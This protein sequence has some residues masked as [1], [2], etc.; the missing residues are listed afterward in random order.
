MSIEVIVSPS[1]KVPT[2]EFSSRLSSAMSVA[3]SLNLITVIRIAV[4]PEVEPVINSPIAVVKSELP[5][6]VTRIT[7][8]VDHSPSDERNRLSLVLR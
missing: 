5:V 2:I 4:A 6:S 7:L 8:S 3:P 1:T